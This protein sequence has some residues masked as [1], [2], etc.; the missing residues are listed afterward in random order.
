MARETVTTRRPL[1][2]QRSWQAPLPSPHHP[3]YRQLQKPETGPTI[4]TLLAPSCLPPPHT[5]H[6]ARPTLPHHIPLVPVLQAS[7]PTYQCMYLANTSPNQ[8]PILQNLSSRGGCR[9]KCH[10]PHF[11]KMCPA[12]I[13]DQTSP[14]YTK[15]ASADNCTEG[16]RDQDT[17]GEHM[18][19]I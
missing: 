19:H 16:K 7:T 8:L 14:Q 10:F 6:V 13:E 12:P 2:E 5:P 15:T 3:A 1:Q 17:I 4:I 9:G 11:I 18:Q